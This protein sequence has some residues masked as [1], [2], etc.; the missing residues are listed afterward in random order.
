MGNK[1]L[2]KTEIFTTI[3]NFK[4]GNYELGKVDISENHSQIKLK[5]STNNSNL[6]IDTLMI[7]TT[8]LKEKYQIV[9]DYSPIYISL[10]ISVIIVIIGGGYYYYKKQHKK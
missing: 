3:L 1:E 4:E 5:L 7:G 8:E 9:S 10:G 6:T 2:K